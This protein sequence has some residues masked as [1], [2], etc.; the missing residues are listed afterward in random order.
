MEKI[1]E[2]GTCVVYT[3]YNTTLDTVQALKILKHSDETINRVLLEEARICHKIAQENIVTVYDFG[4]SEDNRGYIIMEYLQGRTIKELLAC[5]EMPRLAALCIM[6]Y[7]TR[8]LRAVHEKG[9]VHQDIHESNIVI[10][11]EAKVK[12]ADFG[13]AGEQGKKKARY[14]RYA[15]TMSPEQ[16][17]DGEIDER[18][19]IYQAGLLLARMLTGL[20]HTLDTRDEVLEAIK[21]ECMVS[22]DTMNKYEAKIIHTCLRYDK[23]QRYDTV[24]ALE[25]D[26]NAYFKSIRA[27]MVNPADIIRLYNEGRIGTIKGID[28]IERRVLTK[29]RIILLAVLIVSSLALVVRVPVVKHIQQMAMSIDSRG[30]TT[31][32]HRDATVI[33]GMKRQPLQDSIS[34]ISKRD[35]VSHASQK[36]GPGSTIAASDNTVSHASQKSKDE[37]KETQRYG[38][39]AG[40]ND[41]TAVSPHGNG[42]TKERG[43][44]SRKGS[45]SYSLTAQSRM[46]Q[47]VKAQG[48][49]TPSAHETLTGDTMSKASAENFIRLGKQAYARGELQASIRALRRAITTKPAVRNRQEVIREALYGIARVYDKLYVAGRCSKSEYKHVWKKV[50]EVYTPGNSRYEEAKISY[51]IY[52]ETPQKVKQK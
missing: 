43:V 9:I 49:T 24:V 12:I 28:K 26:I 34:G 21:N 2:G 19:D 4:I 48:G 41:V 32:I 31:R 46:G 37:H 17:E 35:T 27:R 25:R 23:H 38:I 5:T 45:G 3:V 52:A 1:G 51:Q 39:Q 29:Q 6:L 44:G 16:L 50:M 10:T 8:A 36:S 14:T 30:V 11:E 7:I 42:A 47:Y 15:G 20:P 18:S 33:S 13:L 22:I 40:S